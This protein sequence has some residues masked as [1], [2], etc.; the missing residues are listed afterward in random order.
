[1]TSRRSANADVINRG[2]GRH[3]VVAA[4][5]ALVVSL[6]LH[7]AVLTKIHSLDLFPQTTRIETKRYTSISMQD[8]E[9]NPPIIENM[10][11]QP[12]DNPEIALR[13]ESSDVGL[14]ELSAPEPVRFPLPEPRANPALSDHEDFGDVLSAPVRQEVLAI[15]DQIYD[16]EIS[17]LPRRWSQKDIPRIELAPD[18]QLPVQ[19]SD[20]THRATVIPD[21]IQPALFIEDHEAGTPEWSNLMYAKGPGD[22]TGMPVMPVSNSQNLDSILNERPE[23]VS[24]LEAIEDLLQVKVSGNGSKNSDGSIYFALSIER[25]SNETLPV[26][27]RDLLFIQ[28][29]SESITP[30]KLDE[31]RRGL[32][33]WLDFLNAGDRFEILS[34]RDDINP[35][36]GEWRTFNAASRQ[37]A[38]GFID[39]LRSEGNTDVYK[40][41]QSAMS[42]DPEE[43]RTMLVVLITDGRPTVGVTGSSE[44]IEGVTRSNQGRVSIFTVGGGKKVN[45]FFLDLMSYRNR[46]D[47]IVVKGKEEIPGAMEEWAMQLQRPV[48][49]DLSYSFANIEES[50]IFPKQLTHLFLD[51]P[52]VIHGRLPADTDRFVFQ[53]VGRAGKEWHDMV[54]VIN[55]DQI[56]NGSSL[57][58]EQWAWQKTYHMI[59]EYIGA[60]SPE[61]LETIRSF[62]DEHELIVPYG[63]SRSLPR[64]N[65]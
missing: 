43:G 53:I 16:N 28:D 2:I 60:E 34:F 59:G 39:G 56:A 48:L 5:L 13:A 57:I 17:A 41:I 25:A 51:R 26:Q 49:T 58:R 42:I 63:F 46:G 23:D 50:D 37:E 33:R 45:S 12:L 44:I 20:Q 27:P 52:L 6:G 62:S 54:F 11:R 18:I 24:E 8:I 22:F 19:L 38:F 3:H 10:D 61:R 14:S 47:A 40:S 30:W 7:A 29:S 35:C 65:R 21:S 55:R 9:L 31:C 15:Q 36:F 4:L 32:K 1:M 64:G